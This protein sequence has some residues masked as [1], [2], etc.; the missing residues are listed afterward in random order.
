MDI[1]TFKAVKYSYIFRFQTVSVDFD[2]AILL[3]SD[4]IG[5]AQSLNLRNDC[6]KV[7]KMRVNTDESEIQEVNPPKTVA[8][9]RTASNTE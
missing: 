9:P 6:L 5:V 7:V 1:F 3:E 4:E 2:E 8:P